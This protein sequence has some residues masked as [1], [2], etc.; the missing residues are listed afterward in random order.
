M[1][2]CVLFKARATALFQRACRHL[3]VPKVQET[4]FFLRSRT[5]ADRK[6]WHAPTGNSFCFPALILLEPISLGIHTSP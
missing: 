4:F 2:L 3:L 1:L 5:V 6:Q